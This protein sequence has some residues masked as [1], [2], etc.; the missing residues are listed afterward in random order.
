MDARNRKMIKQK[1]SPDGKALLLV[2]GK[3]SNK[4][5]QLVESI[6]CFGGKNPGDY[7]K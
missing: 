5:G 1:S 2:N 4:S 6:H 3:A 7:T